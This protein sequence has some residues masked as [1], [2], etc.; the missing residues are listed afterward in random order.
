M[1]HS[2]GNPSG[3]W[4]MGDGVTPD[5]LARGQTLSLSPI[6]VTLLWSDGG[7]VGKAT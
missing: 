4:C 7:A 6:M 2:A 1:P 3:T 5:N